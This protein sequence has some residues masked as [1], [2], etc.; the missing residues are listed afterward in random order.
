MT[1]DRD[2]TFEGTRTEQVNVQPPSRVESQAS[3]HIQTPSPVQV[4]VQS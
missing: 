4:S 1:T 3:E 2:P